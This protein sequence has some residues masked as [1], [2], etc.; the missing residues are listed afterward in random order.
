[1]SDRAPRRVAAARRLAEP[2]LEVLRRR[3]L[4]ALVRG[5]AALV[6]KEIGLL[7]RGAVLLRREA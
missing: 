6:S 7:E 2:R 4:R 5:L 3:E 1:M